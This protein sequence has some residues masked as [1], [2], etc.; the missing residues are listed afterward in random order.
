MKNCPISDVLRR[1]NELEEL[2]ALLFQVRA[3]KR[4]VQSDEN[5]EGKV[6]EGSLQTKSIPPFFFTT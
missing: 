1:F 4:F 5:A 6:R 2:A 3:N